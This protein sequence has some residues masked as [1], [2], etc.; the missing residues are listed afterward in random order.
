MAND[1]TALREANNNVKVFGILKEKNLE[2]KSG[3][4]KNGNATKFVS[5]YLV[6]QVDRTNDAGNKE[7]SEISVN[8]YV[9]EFT[10]NGSE[11]KAYKGL[12]TV[13][14][15]YVSIAE[16]MKEGKTKEEA[17]A[18]ADRISV[19]KGKLGLNEFYSDGQLHTNMTINSNFFNRVQDIEKFK[20]E[21]TFDIECVINKF[22]NETKDG[23]ETGRVFIDVYVPMYGGTISPMT[24]VANGDVAEYLK[25]NYKANDSGNLWGDV[26]SIVDRQVVKKSGFGKSKEDVKVTYIRGFEVTGGGEEPYDPDDT[27]KAFNLE[28]VKK[29][30]SEREAEYLPSL[31]AKEN[32]SGTGKPGTHS[33][34]TAAST[35]KSPNFDF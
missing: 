10:K 1:N 35:G 29:A 14:N 12:E 24:F 26:V 6:L 34:A 15:E 17:E 16:L 9:S 4:D 30:L 13:I 2:V 25:D 7:T 5:G 18:Q 8:T 28:A 32:K 20:P 22:R 23:E 33:S 19:S 3:K 21:A 11:N 27:A 31:K